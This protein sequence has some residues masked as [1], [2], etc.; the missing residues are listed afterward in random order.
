MI[1]KHS[2]HYKNNDL[3]NLKKKREGLIFKK[4][5]VTKNDYNQKDITTN[6][7]EIPFSTFINFNPFQRYLINNL[8]LIAPRFYLKNE[9]INILLNPKD[10]YDIFIKKI[11]KSKKRIFLTSLYVDKGLIKVINALDYSLQLNKDLHVDILIDGLRGTRKSSNN[12]SSATLLLPLI[13]KYGCKRIAVKMYQTP[14]FLNLLKKIVPQRFNEGWGLQHMKF[15]GFDDEIILS[16]ANLS[17]DYFSNRQDR[18]F[19]INNSLLTNFYFKLQ[20]LVSSISYELTLDKTKYIDFLLVWPKLN[21]TCDPCLNMKKFLS[22]CSMLFQ[23]LIKQHT[24]ETM[25]KLSQ[26]D[27]FDTIIYP[28]ALINPLLPKNSNISTEL[29]ALIF[30]LSLLEKKNTKIKWWF[31]TGYF[32][33]HSKLQK[34]LL[35]VNSEG[36]LIVA[37]RYSN[38]FYNSKGISR[39]LPEAYFFLLKCFLEKILHHKKENFI[40]VFQ[41]KKGIIGYQN[42]WSY[43]AKGIWISSS[44]VDNP[45]IT[46]IGSSNYTRRSYH[47]DLECNALVITFS[48]QLKSKLKNEV[49]NIML[50][51]IEIN[52][53]DFGVNDLNLR[54]SFFKK[55]SQKILSLRLLR[56][57]SNHL[58]SS[59]SINT[60]SISTKDSNLRKKK[61]STSQNSFSTF[62]NS[63]LSNIEDRNHLI[64]SNRKIGYFVKIFT[65]ILSGVL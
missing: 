22:D 58:T 36:K 49:D 20:S 37:S 51:A 30:L 34:A 27:S 3:F 16:G 13:V 24:T 9:E 50:S 39:H 45:S 23:S 57:F 62:S 2:R 15:Y 54:K 25:N 17:I 32:N 46:V 47:C 31:T 63:N 11:I 14:K 61:D 29:P 65:K 6:N 28:I 19:I 40:S 5:I 56:S 26:I 64:E 33:L 7:P 43:H 1:L 44:D 12:D 38:S 55:A 60:H 4:K 52:L 18:Y 59:N 10:F 41:W 48:E 21:K 8:D 35:N 42:G 53:S